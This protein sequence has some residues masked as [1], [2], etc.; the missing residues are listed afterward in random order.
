REPRR[1]IPRQLARQGD[2]AIAQRRVAGKFLDR[3]AEISIHE[4]AIRIEVE[5]FGGS[6]FRTMN[7]GGGETGLHLRGFHRAVEL[8]L[9]GQIATPTGSEPTISR[10]SWPSCASR[11]S[12]ST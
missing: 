10:L 11:Q 2:V 8:H 3:A 5:R 7:A 4:G 6:K 9:S 12:N 1:S